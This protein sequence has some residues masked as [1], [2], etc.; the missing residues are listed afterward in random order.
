MDRNIVNDLNQYQV[1]ICLFENDFSN[2]MNQLANA[3]NNA[4][5]NPRNQLVNV[6][7]DQRFEMSHVVDAVFVATVIV[8][9][10][11]IGVNNMMSLLANHS[12]VIRL[13]LHGFIS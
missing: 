12:L 7:G 11:L 1:P 6:L 10:N 13:L 2:A 3:V 9:I 8:W 5:C 4:E